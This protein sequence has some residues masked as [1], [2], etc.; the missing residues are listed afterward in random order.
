MRR[1]PK[2]SLKAFGPTPILT[3]GGGWI[4]DDKV[5]AVD[6]RVLGPFEVVD[7]GRVLALG[8]PKQRAV[9]AMLA[10][11]VGRVVTRDR[12]VDGVWGDAAADTAVQT[13]QVYVS[14]LRRVLGSGRD[15]GPAI[16]SRSPGYLLD[17]DP[18]DVDARRFERLLTVGRK[19]LVEDRHEAAARTLSGALELWRGAPLADL[20]DSDFAGPEVARLQELRLGGIED[21]VEADLAC[22]RHVALVA[23][24]RA[25]VAAHPFRERLWSQLMLALYRSGLQLDALEAYATS[26]RILMDDFGVEPGPELR[27]MERRILNQDLSLAPPPG[28]R[29]A[30]VKLPAP[31]HPVL[32]RE[33]D[34]AALMDALA[35]GARL[36]TVTGPGGMGK[37]SVTLQLAAELVDSYPGGVFFVPLAGVADPDQVL[38]AVAQALEVSQQPDESLVSS[39]SVSLGQHSALLIV[40]NLEQVLGAGPLMVDLLDACPALVVI[41]TSRAPLHV[42]AEREY[43]LG[44]LA[45]PHT[46]DRDGRPLGVEIE[47][48][49]SVQLFVARAR[50]VRPEFA[51]TATTAGVIAEI[52]ERLD[53]QPLALE[54]AAAR[55]VTLDPPALLA[56]LDRQLGLLTAGPRDLPDRQ[57][58]L[59]S[60]LD[61]SYALLTVEARN[62][63]ARLGS[64]SGDLSLEM[65]EALSDDG[66]AIMH[67]TTLID[68]N[69]VRRVERDGT[70]RYR[71]LTSVREYAASS[72]PSREMKSASVPSSAPCSW[73][74]WRRRST[75]S[76]VQRP[77][78][79]WLVSRARTS[80]CCRRCGGRLTAVT[81]PLQQGLPSRYGSSGSFAGGSRR[82]GSGWV[83]S[84]SR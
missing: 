52:C 42:R 37:T 19:H 27:E 84:W 81:P 64:A 20:G 1:T 68:N 69:L 76:T 48:A 78:G 44:S 53:G 7:D 18:D 60:T 57:R 24:L 5:A 56:R 47:Q 33:T 70:S 26:R 10:L 32:G 4:R 49:A 46:A 51:V 61:W 73:P 77:R 9:L 54:L 79:H 40:D 2:K 38:P 23:E 62:L 72:W 58:T 67:L 16:V 12:L 29:R 71:L 43:P 65:V 59:R 63:L 82:G 28:A 80:T 66:D 11:D 35:D 45:L 25:L 15:G 34:L 6:V 17:I 21:R 13:L 31:T 74:A 14:M 41:A 55:V 22:G 39:I 36:L 30:T 83:A 50:E 75:A 3:T 8:G